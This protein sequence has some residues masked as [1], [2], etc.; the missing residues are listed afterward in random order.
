[1]AAAF[2]GYY[3]KQGV[4]TVVTATLSG[5][6][7]TVIEEGALATDGT[8]QYALLDTV[9]IGEGGTVE[10]EFQC[11]ETGAIPCPAGH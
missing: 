7:N 5:T 8:Y 9:T 1:M 2:F 10:A 4:G 6:A 3:R 11:T